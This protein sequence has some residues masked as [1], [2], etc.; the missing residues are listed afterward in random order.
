MFNEIKRMYLQ[1]VEKKILIFRSMW[2]FENENLPRV[3][4]FDFYRF[5]NWIPKN[6]WSAVCLISKIVKSDIS[7]DQHIQLTSWPTF[8]KKP[9]LL[10]DSFFKLICFN[11]CR[12]VTC[13][14]VG[15]FLFWN[16]YYSINQQKCSCFGNPVLTATSV[17][18]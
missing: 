13:Y 4:V 7:T 17:P 14:N 5:K 1:M 18:I 3:R 11:I 2:L 16:K 9:S 8:F 10:W 12:G 6:T 15:A